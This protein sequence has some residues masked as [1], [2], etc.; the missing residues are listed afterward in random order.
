MAT[1]TGTLEVDLMLKAILDAE[2]IEVKPSEAFAAPEGPRVK[3][4]WKDPET[5][6][7]SGILRVYPGASLGA[8]VHPDAAH[9]LYVLEGTCQIS[10]QVLTRGSYVFVRPGEEHRIEEAGPRGCTLLSLYLRTRPR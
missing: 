9:H 4:L 1:S 5:G 6:S 2:H 8:R 7:Y 10:G 3:V